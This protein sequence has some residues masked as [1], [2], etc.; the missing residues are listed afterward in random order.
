[1]ILGVNMSW[2]FH[3]GFYNSSSSSPFFSFFF[4]FFFFFSSVCRLNTNKDRYSKH[5]C[6]VT[7]LSANLF[8]DSVLEWRDLI[9]CEMQLQASS[10]Q[11][12]QKEMV[13]QSIYRPGQALSVTGSWGSQISRQ[14]AHEGGKAVIPMHR[15]PLTPRKYSWYSFLLQAESIPGPLWGRKD[16][17]NE[18]F[19]WH[20]RE[21]NPRP[22]GL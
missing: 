2:K 19:Q 21:S 5:P 13:K 20:H 16:Y 17:V 3:F 4:F 9:G 22:S 6:D 14:S 1:M 8:G 15:L 10:Q 11:A 12:R 18:K 7:S